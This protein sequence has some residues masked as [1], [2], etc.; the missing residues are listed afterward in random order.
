MTSR[1]DARGSRAVVYPHRYPSAL[2]LAAILSGGRP[3]TVRVGVE[4][5]P[6]RSTIGADAHSRTYLETTMKYLC[7]IY[8]EE[9]K[10]A[11]MPKN[12]S[13]A[14]MGEYFAF[15]NTIRQSGH[16]VAGDALKSVQ[17]A[18]TVRVRNGKQST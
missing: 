5:A 17:T 4:F 13:D 1:P 8:D 14:F 12:E 16:F 3:A 15:S 11:A 18:T 9:K 6:S 7:L 10:L 2:V